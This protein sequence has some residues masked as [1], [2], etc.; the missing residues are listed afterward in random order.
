MAVPKTPHLRPSVWSV[1]RSAIEG[2]C[3]CLGGVNE[4]SSLSLGAYTREPLGDSECIRI[5]FARWP[6]DGFH[7]VCTFP[8]ARSKGSSPHVPAAW[9]FL[10][11]IIAHRERDPR[12]F[13]CNAAIVIP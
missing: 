7:F 5:F 1:A 4:G 3:D 12:Y 2:I 13:Q 10:T 9:F 8:G 6:P 11:V